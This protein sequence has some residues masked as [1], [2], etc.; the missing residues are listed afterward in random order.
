M[1]PE[2]ALQ[3]G[4]ELFRMSLPIFL[5]TRCR[6]RWR[7]Q[8]GIR[9]FN[10]IPIGRGPH[11]VCTCCASNHARCSSRFIS[12]HD[13]A[14]NHVVGYGCGGSPG[15]PLRGRRRRARRPRAKEPRRDETCTVSGDEA[16][17]C[18]RAS[19]SWR[20]TRAQGLRPRRYGRLRNSPIETPRM[21]NWK[22][23]ENERRTAWRPEN[24]SPSKLAGSQPLAI[25]LEHGAIA[26]RFHA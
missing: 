7:R 1:L 13:S 8:Q 3:R 4:I 26:R 20:I 21:P 6:G 17:R 22:C 16:R 23:P 5:W 14:S 9:R 10:C 19:S 18:F 24:V 2:P 12:S 11:G 15:N 25:S